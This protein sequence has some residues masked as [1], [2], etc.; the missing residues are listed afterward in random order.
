MDSKYIGFYVK[1]TG[2]GFPEDEKDKIFNRFYKIEIDK[3]KLYR[4]AGLGLALAKGIIINLKGDMWVETQPGVGT[5]FFFKIPSIASTNV[6]ESILDHDQKDSSALIGKKILIAEDNFK[7][8]SY[9]S[10]VLKRGGME[11]VNAKNG[12]EA[13]YLNNEHKFDL[14]LMD[15]LMPE[16][17]G[18]EATK[19]IKIKNP[20]IPIIAQSAFNFSKDDQDLI[21]LFDDVL[22]KPIKPSDLILTLTKH[23]IKPT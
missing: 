22:I 6:D 9:L 2:C 16:M 14:I 13:V 4:G 8:Y 12:S 19:K 1:D 15:I 3:N 10:I 21:N 7:N 18:F 11:A 20:H 17:D 5:T 23:L